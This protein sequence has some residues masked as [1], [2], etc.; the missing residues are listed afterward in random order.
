MI[1]ALKRYPRVEFD[2]HK[3]LDPAIHGENRTEMQVF[4]QRSITDEFH[5]LGQPFWVTKGRRTHSPLG[6]FGKRI[7][8]VDAL[9]H[10]TTTT[11]WSDKGAVR[12]TVRQAVLDPKMKTAFADGIRTKL[13]D[14]YQHGLPTRP[15]RS[16]K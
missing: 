1:D 11:G 7:Y 14:D 3:P 5:G 9:L 10:Q 16:F 8:T 12:R 15:K 2:G 4:V 13:T 6:L